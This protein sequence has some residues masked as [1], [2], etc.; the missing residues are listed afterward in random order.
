MCNGLMSRCSTTDH[1]VRL[2]TYCSE[3][4]LGARR[5][6]NTFVFYFTPLVYETTKNCAEPR[7]SE[8]G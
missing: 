3:A 2:E 5:F 8:E 7:A 1:L 6:G 4:I